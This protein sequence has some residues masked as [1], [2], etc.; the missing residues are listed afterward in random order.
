MAHD[1]S[2]H[3]HS[4]TH[5]HSHELTSG[6]RLYWAAAI[7]IGL[8]GVEVVAGILSHSQ[9]LIADGVHNFADAGALL[10][11]VAARRIAA[12]PRNDRMSYGYK[13]A[14]ILGALINS[15]ALIG[16]A[17]F[18]V[19]ESIQSLRVPPNIHAETMMGV[20]G[21][22]LVIDLM[23]AFL[24][25]GG[26]KSNL[27]MRAVFLHNL[28][29]AATSVVVILSGA[30]IYFWGFTFAD[31]LATL[32]IAAY[33]VY[34]SYGLIQHCV[35]ILMNAVPDHLS[36]PKVKAALETIP[37]VREAFHIH[38]WQLDEHSYFF[39]GEICL[40]NDQDRVSVKQQARTLLKDSFSIHHAIIEVRESS[41][42]HQH[43]GCGEED[44]S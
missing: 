23:T 13:R 20:A 24:T 11:A 40:T 12:L 6:S 30:L 3:S 9:S 8:T 39:E 31:G 19:I 5:D 35:R 21:V 15:V 34:H 18:L 22:A 1:H 33:L 38:V 32:L 27:N 37:G 26:S 29:D 14:E 17:F 43:D 10:I 2:G 7:N 28:L 41:D 25:Y 16:I 42:P 4:H 36:L 44:P